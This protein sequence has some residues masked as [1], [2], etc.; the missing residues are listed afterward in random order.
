MTA[1][2]VLLSIGVVLCSFGLWTIAVS[3][4]FFMSL[5]GAGMM[6]TGGTAVFLIASYQPPK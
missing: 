2:T 5:L 3:E 6:S 4:G 1:S